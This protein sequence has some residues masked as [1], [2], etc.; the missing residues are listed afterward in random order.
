MPQ[1]PQNAKPHQKEFIPV[2]Q[3]LDGLE[4]N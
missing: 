3:E 2:S 1:N 4:K